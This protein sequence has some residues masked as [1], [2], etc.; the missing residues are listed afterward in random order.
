M[1]R[2]KIGMNML[3]ALP[4]EEMARIPADAGYLV[5]LPSDEDKT[6]H[7]ATLSGQSGRWGVW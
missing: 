1:K 4:L 5:R 7:M 6:L 3:K 2:G